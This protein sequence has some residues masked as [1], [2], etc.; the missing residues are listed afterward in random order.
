MTAKKKG[1]ASH[2]FSLNEIKL[3][4]IIVDTRE[5]TPLFE[6]PPSIKGTLHNGDYSLRGFEDVIA[7]ER[8]SISDLL[9]SVGQRRKHFLMQVRRCSQV[10]GC[11]LIEGSIRAVLG[12]KPRGKMNGRNALAALMSWS[13]AYGIP[14][15]FADGLLEAQGVA[16]SWMK[17]AR[18]KICEGGQYRHLGLI[19]SCGGGANIG[20][21]GNCKWQ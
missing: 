14:V 16:I 11:I 8:K 20:H 4:E 17:F 12:Y 2:S 13:V 21:K 7:I 1:S 5:T 10:E 6:C 15:F 9:G 3:G 18:R 19:C